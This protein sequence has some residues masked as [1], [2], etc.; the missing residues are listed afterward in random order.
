MSAK[1]K[2]IPSL[3]LIVIVV[4]FS[5]FLR[6]WNAEDKYVFTADE[7]YQVTYASTI[8]KDFHPVWIGVSAANTGF[9]LGPW[10]T[11]LTAGLLK[12]SAGDPLIT[13]YLT[14]A[15]GA[16]ATAL[17]YVL[18]KAIFGSKTGLLAGLIYATSPLLVYF[19]QRYW[20]P[21]LLPV[22]SLVLLLSLIKL[23]ESYWWLIPFSAAYALVFN[24]H[25][26]LIPYALVLIPALLF[27]QSKSP[28]RKILP[29]VLVSLALFAV[30][31]S[32]LIV[33]DLVHFII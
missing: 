17:V 4:A 5:F 11:Y 24:S 10:F 8:I 33:F 25:L 2:R 30:I 23:K 15:L 14:A 28:R 19:D 6:L 13:I 32:P 16:A 29:P 22:L 12:I 31:Y 26:S 9:Y 18:G 7:E 1:P 21:S 27:R 20:N 3:V